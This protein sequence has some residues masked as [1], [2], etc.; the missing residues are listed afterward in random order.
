ML[1]LITAEGNVPIH[2]VGNN[3]AV[4]H[5]WNGIDTLHFEVHMIHHPQQTASE[6]PAPS[7]PSDDISSLHLGCFSA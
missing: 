2:D 3:Y 6:Y 5:K 4:T 1:E 7:F